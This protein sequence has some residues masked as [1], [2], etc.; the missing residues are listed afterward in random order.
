[1]NGD[2]EELAALVRAGNKIEAIKRLRE[3]TGLGLREA[4]DAVERIDSAGAAQLLLQ[5]MPAAP[6]GPVPIDA[7]VRLLAQ[8]GKRIDAIK[9]LRE[10]KRMG[11]KEA[12]D[13]LDAAVPP[14]PMNLR[15]LGWIA[16][17]I[18]AV[19]AYVLIEVS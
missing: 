13:A 4:K 2:A 9:L 10:R 12:K 19:L 8:Q 16:I 14:P 11:L 1:M 3:L 18:A 6:Q 5:R 7:D 17:A 15:P